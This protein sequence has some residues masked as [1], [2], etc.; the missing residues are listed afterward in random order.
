MEILRV[1]IKHITLK[2]LN[3]LVEYVKKQ[4]T[5]NIKPI[6]AVYVINGYIHS[7]PTSKK[8]HKARFNTVEHLF[9][10]PCLKKSHLIHLLTKNRKTIHMA[11]TYS[12]SHLKRINYLYF[13]KTDFN[14]MIATHDSSFS[15]LHLNIS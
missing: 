1:I 9:F 4:L 2:W 14:K 3:S 13:E 7:A 15:L 8:L 6:A 10:I 5:I 11:N 12:P